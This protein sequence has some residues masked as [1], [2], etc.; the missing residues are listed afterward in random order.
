MGIV[1]STAGAD[2]IIACRSDFADGIDDGADVAGR[3]SK[4]ELQA[5]RNG[6]TR[7]VNSTNPLH[8]GFRKAPS[9]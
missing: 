5:E 6:L 1:I 9:S 8:A 4:H 2:D 3:S 7:K